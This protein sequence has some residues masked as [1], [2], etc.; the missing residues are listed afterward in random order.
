MS[1]RLLIVVA[2]ALSGW[3]LADPLVP[4]PGKT[5]SLKFAVIG[6]NGT[7]E[8]PQ[9]DVGRQMAQARAA[10]PFELVL[11]LGDNMYGRQSPQDFVDK[12][13][14]PYAALLQAGVP[15]Y[16]TLGN[17][18]DPNN[19]SY[20]GFHMDGAR[21]Y[22]FT[23]KS[24]RFFVF[25]TN[26]LDRPQQAWIEQTLKAAT[27]PWRIA[28]FHHPLY[29]DAGRHG[30]NVELR[31]VL[32]PLL[33]QNGVDVVFS[34]HDHAYERITAQQGINFVLRQNF[35]HASLGTVVKKY[36]ADENCRARPCS[37][38]CKIKAILTSA[39]PVG[40]GCQYGPQQR[41]ACL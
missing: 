13:E 27:E 22:T 3:A 5:D 41:R 29:S 23:R 31:V 19:R 6:D 38:I 9:F 36:V 33:V 20:P 15:F 18:D 4:L 24:V 25:D 1:T 30:S 26:L 40:A 28:Y 2:A 8:A 7:G 37:G 11:M 14:R 12:F 34:G 16:A 39:L 17:H 35:I 32:E 21:Y 10:F